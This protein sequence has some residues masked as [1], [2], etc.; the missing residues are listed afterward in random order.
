MHEIATDIVQNNLSARLTSDVI[1]VLFRN[2][3]FK[4]F[5][6]KIKQHF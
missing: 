6:I 4:N 3:E 5:H 2:L 1:S